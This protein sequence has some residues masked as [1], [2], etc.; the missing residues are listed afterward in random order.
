MK[1]RILVAA[2]SLILA[3]LILLLLPVPS[4]DPG[5]TTGPT[6][7]TQTTQGTKP[8]VTTPPSDSQPTQPGVVRVYSC[9]TRF[10][11]VLTE[12]AA[13]YFALTGVEVVVLPPEEGRGEDGVRS[14][15]QP[16]CV[17]G[18]SCSCGEKA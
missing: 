16:A 10:V 12:L 8:T 9:E 18:S 17:C 7:P 4:D 3:A 11:T 15:E 2:A 5:V 6:V 1:K 14:V 13:E